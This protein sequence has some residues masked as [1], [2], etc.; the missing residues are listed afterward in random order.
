MVAITT[1]QFRGLIE[2]AGLE[3]AV[4]G[5]EEDLGFALQ[6]DGDLFNAREG[7]AGILE[8]WISSQPL[9][10]IAALFDGN[11]VLWGPYQTM[12][13]LL[14]NDARATAGNPMLEE[15]DQPGIGPYLMPGSPL[16]VGSDRIPPRPAPVLGQH[17]DEVLSQ[18]LG[19]SGVEIG[20]LHDGKV[21]ASA[22]SI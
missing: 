12:R 18:V 21:V 3:G 17:T 19:L 4:A 15:V 7:I 5:L 20:R 10:A 2:A 8:S 1:R 22:V 6:S 11:R 9:G 16:D 14:E 13:E